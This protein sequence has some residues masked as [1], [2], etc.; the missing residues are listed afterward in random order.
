MDSEEE[1]SSAG[2]DSD[3]SDGGVEDHMV[4]NGPLQPMQWAGGME[5]DDDSESS[6]GVSSNASSDGNA[7]ARG[8]AG[9]HLALEADAEGP[10]GPDFGNE[11]ADDQPSSS[12]EDS[13]HND[14]AQEL[15]DASSSSDSEVW[16]PHFLNVSE[17]FVD[18]SIRDPLPMGK[19][20]AC[21]LTQTWIQHVLA[22]Q[23]IGHAVAVACWGGAAV[24]PS[25]CARIALM[26]DMLLV[27]A[28]V[29]RPPTHQH[30][31]MVLDLWC[32]ARTPTINPILTFN[33]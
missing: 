4:A 24:P 2:E 5:S 26:L 30:N 29:L 19:S 16:Y 33:T 14:E 22:R 17:T 9:P 3:I 20:A 10:R 7:D 13:E 31:V 8:A 18:W 15:S 1:S 28:V 21:S 23:N 11:S 6:S 25:G 27:R 32:R 12:D